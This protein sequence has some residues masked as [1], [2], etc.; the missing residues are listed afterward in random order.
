MED[1]GVA[2]LHVE[3]QVN[4]KRCGHLEGKQVVDEATAVRRVRAAVDARRDPDFLV[5][6]RTD[7]RGWRVSTPPCG[8]RRPSSTRRRR[9]LRRGHGRPVGVRGDLRR[10]RRPRPGQHDRVRP[11]RPVHPRPAARRRR[12]ASSSTPSRCC[13]W[14]WGPPTAR[15]RVDPTGTLEPAVGRHADPRRVVRPRRLRR[16]RRVRLLRVRLQ[17]G[18]EPRKRPDDQQ[19]SGGV[20][21]DTTASRRS[22]PTRTRCCTGGTRAGAGDAALVRGGRAVAVGRRPARRRDPRRLPGP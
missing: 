7:V 19:G 4:P 9:R 8:V 18:R 10:P 6:A 15:W 13:G 21:A 22:T 20:V 12:S 17:P 3:D 2:G 1:A 14:R 16:L 5:V 11:Q